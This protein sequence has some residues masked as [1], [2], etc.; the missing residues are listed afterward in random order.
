MAARD[1][2]LTRQFFEEILVTTFNL[3]N[4]MVR[5][6]CLNMMLEHLESGEGFG[7]TEM[8][9]EVERHMN[10]AA[11]HKSTLVQCLK[12]FS[13]MRKEEDSVS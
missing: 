1:R 2:K 8:K 11:A 4:R 13:E 9:A 5:I 6:S 3:Q 12:L 7:T 10:Q